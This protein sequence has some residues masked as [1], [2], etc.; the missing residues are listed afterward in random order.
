MESVQLTHL[1]LHVF[2]SF[3]VVVDGYIDF[4]VNKFYSKLLLEN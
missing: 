4:A 1:D 2:S 3:L